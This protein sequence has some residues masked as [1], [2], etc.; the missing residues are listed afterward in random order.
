VA[1]AATKPFPL[2]RPLLGVTSVHYQQLRKSKRRAQE[3]AEYRRLLD[4]LLK[5]PRQ[6]G[7][8]ALVDYGCGIRGV[9][10][11]DGKYRGQVWVASD[12]GAYYMPFGQ[13]EELHTGSSSGW[14]P[15]DTPR[16]Y[17]FLDW[18]EHWVCN[19][20]VPRSKAKAGG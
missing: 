9:L 13:H 7:V 16:E 15:T 12:D 10:V 4:A 20:Q 3:A 19:V 17:G 6:D 2:S 1:P 8:L 14:T 11:M 18:Y 5:V